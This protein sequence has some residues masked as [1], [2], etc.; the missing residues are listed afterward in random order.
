MIREEEGEA[1]P[2]VARIRVYPL[3]GAAGFDLP[4]V[5]LDAFGIPGDR[6]WMLVRPDGLF[7]SQRTHPR[8]ALIHL[9]PFPEEGPTTEG[10]TTRSGHGDP[11]F[12]ARAPGMDPLVLGPFPE[13][14]PRMEVRIHRDTAVGVVVEEAKEWFCTYLRQECH[15]VYSPPALR[16]PVDPAFAPGHRTGFSD[17]YP[18]L[19]TS[20]ESLE[21]LNRRLSRPSSMLRFRPNLVLRGG[22]AWEEDRWRTLEV[23]EVRLDLVKPCARCSVTTV[24]PGTAV[25]GKEPLRTLSGFRGWEGKAYFGQNA[26]FSGRGSFRVGENVRI[27]EKGDARPPLGG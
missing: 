11:P 4:A 25:R 3:K 21:D 27:V 26:V 20:E 7:I 15:L 23:G 1:R 13:G 6:C 12:L 18:L 10:G 5:T 14:G 9:S 2:Q 8:L 24:D 19:L 22:R 17:A 16:R